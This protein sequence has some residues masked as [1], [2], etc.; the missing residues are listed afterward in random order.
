MIAESIEIF[1]TFVGDCAG[2]PLRRVFA[3]RGVSL[4]DLAESEGARRIPCGASGCNMIRLARNKPG[5]KG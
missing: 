2:P 5:L 1:P 4:A 3:F